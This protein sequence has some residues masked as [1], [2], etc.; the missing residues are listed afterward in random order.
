MIF[1]YF[2]AMFA[3]MGDLL[4]TIYFVNRWGSQLEGNPL[5]RWT[6][7]SCGLANAMVINYAFFSTVAFLQLIGPKSQYIK[8]MA[9]LMIAVVL[10]NLINILLRIYVK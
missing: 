6:I 8:Y 3:K 10:W 9:F 5:V 1:W 4:T 2:V 7:N